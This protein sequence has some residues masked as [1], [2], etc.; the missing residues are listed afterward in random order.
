[1]KEQAL[2]ATHYEPLYK[3]CL[4]FRT[5]FWEKLPTPCLGGQS[6]ADLRFRWIVYPSNDIG[7]AG[8]SGLLLYCWMNDAYRMASL[9][10][11][12]RVS[13]VLH[14]LQRFYEDTGVSISDEFIDAFD[15]CWSQESATGDA[16]AVSTLSGS[17]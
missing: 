7:S 8:S 11:D 6:V 16:M 1:M 17:I 12:Q 10:R 9:P 2:R 5:R 13:L 3:I 14:D 4:H 15:V